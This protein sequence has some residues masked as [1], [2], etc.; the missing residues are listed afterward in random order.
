M[1]KQ[2][3]KWIAY[4][5][6][7]LSFGIILNGLFMSGKTVHDNMEAKSLKADQLMIATQDKKK[8]VFNIELALTVPEQQKGLMN[9]ENI[10]E[11]YGMLFIYDRVQDIT[12]WMKNTPSPLDMLFI[13]NNGKILWIT[14]NA[15]PYDE[16]TISSHF[17]V[18]A[19]LEIKGGQVAAR[20]IK[21]GDIVYNSYFGNTDK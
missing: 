15:K 5:A 8:H 10:P 13:D 6:I 4:A 3:V 18:R 21:L 12:M 9:R 14:E 17:P 1:P 11:D 20:G 19:T 7:I 2:F 16:R